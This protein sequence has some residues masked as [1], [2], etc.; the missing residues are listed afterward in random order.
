MNELGSLILAPIALV[1]YL[2]ASDMTTHVS[3]ATQEH[4]GQGTIVSLL[5]SDSGWGMDVKAST[6]GLYAV[7]V[8]YGLKAETGPWSIAVLPK[9]GVSV[10][11]HP[12]RE[13]PQTVQFSVGAQVLGGYDHLRVGVELWHLSNA[14][15][16]SPNIG[17]NMVALQAGWRF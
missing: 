14:G 5:S 16:T 9:A 8:Q 1:G 4:T 12:V 3:K 2:Y 15:M 11:D 13:L 10:T 7:D 6:N 17:L